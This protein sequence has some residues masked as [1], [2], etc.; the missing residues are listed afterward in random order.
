MILCSIRFPKPARRIVAIVLGVVL[1]AATSKIMSETIPTFKNSGPSLPKTSAKTEEQ[2]QDFL[3]E[4]GWNATLVE[5]ESGEVLIP[6]E[7]DEVY[8]KYNLIQQEQGLDLTKF[9]GKDAMKYTYI[10]ANHP[11]GNQNMRI[12]LL[13]CKNKVV[14]GDLCS[15]GPNG[16]IDPL[17]FPSEQ[18]SAVQFEEDVAPV[19]DVT[20]SEDTSKS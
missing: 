4:L 6:E 5:A 8:E 19:E 10:V 13:V 1:V 12:H 11:D 3:S 2:R 7:F 17:F 18:N 15:L 9:K 14:A 16:F 20:P